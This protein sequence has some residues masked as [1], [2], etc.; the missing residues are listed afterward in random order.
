[1]TFEDFIRGLI[2]AHQAEYLSVKVLPSEGALL[3]VIHPAG[4]C[5]DAVERKFQITGDTV[6]PAIT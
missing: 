4:V 1:M 5:G 6:I 3:V 2:D